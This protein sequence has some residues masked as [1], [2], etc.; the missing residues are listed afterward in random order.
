VTVNPEDIKGLRAGDYIQGPS[1]R[2]VELGRVIGESEKK[3]LTENPAALTDFF[4]S[5]AAGGIRQSLQQ[6]RL[7]RPAEADQKTAE[8]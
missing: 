7:Q 8:A 2:F 4:S 6:R 1:I 3:L 5:I